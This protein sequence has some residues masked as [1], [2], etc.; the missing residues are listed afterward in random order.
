MIRKCFL[1][2]WFFVV[3]L[4]GENEILTTI[5]DIYIDGPCEETGIMTVVINADEF[6]AA[7]SDNPAYI[8]IRF[9]HDVVL[10][11][12]LVDY[13]APNQRHINRPIYLPLSREGSPNGNTVIAPPATIAIVRWIAGESSIWLRVSSSSSGWLSIAGQPS[14]P[15]P[16]ER[17]RFTVGLTARS[18]WGA[19][20]SD[21]TNGRANLPA[22]TRDTTGLTEGDAVS[23]LICVDLR[24]SNLQPLPNPAP[25]SLLEF[26]ATAQDGFTQK[27]TTA[28]HEVGIEPGGQLALT[29]IGDQRI[30]R[31]YD[32]SCVSSINGQ[33]ALVSTPLCGMLG[34]QELVAMSNQLRITV[35]CGLGWG[36]HRG[37]RIVLETQPGESY[38]FL[39][40]LDQNGQFIDASDIAGAEG[41]V[42]LDGGTIDINTSQSQPYA[43]LSAGV[44]QAGPHF[45]ARQAIIQYLGPGTPFAFDLSIDASVS[46]HFQEDP[47]SVDLRVTPFHSNRDSELDVSPFDGEEQVRF[48]CA[49]LREAPTLNWQM[50]NFVICP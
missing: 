39:I 14:A 32:F 47:V 42:L 37:S 46:M 3:A 36:F 24:D 49:G 50:G 31:G 28:E 48:C 9:N 43:D 10:C 5:R 34:G 17:V 40:Q 22:A 19:Y 2:N 20:I 29:F 1:V 4:F 15:G 26:Y 27:V 25:L 11:K 8:R 21:F 44:I 18:S 12:T 16:A 30:A 41:F 6:P 7:S 38:G 33:A 23:T 35:N 13:D 45:L